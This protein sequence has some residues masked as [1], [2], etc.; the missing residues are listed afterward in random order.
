MIKLKDAMIEAVLHDLGVREKIGDM[1]HWN[2][3]LLEI[4]VV[5]RNFEKWAKP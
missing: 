3:V 4:D 1:V 2:A 5:I